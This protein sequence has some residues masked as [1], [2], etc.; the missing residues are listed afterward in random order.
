[1][2]FGDVREGAP[3]VGEQGGNKNRQSRVFGAADA[4]LTAESASPFDNDFI[5]R[6]LQQKKRSNPWIRVERFF[7]AVSADGSMRVGSAIA[8]GH[9]DGGFHHTE[10]HPGA[11]D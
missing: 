11:Q 9:V 1:L 10:G 3:A 5:H 8:F 6:T 7:P 2:Q 4:Y